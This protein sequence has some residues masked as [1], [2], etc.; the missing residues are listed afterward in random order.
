MGGLDLSKAADQNFAKGSP[1]WGLNYPARLRPTKGRTHT[2]VRV[3]RG[4]AVDGDVGGQYHSG[5]LIYWGDTR[6]AAQGGL[7]MGHTLGAP[8]WGPLE[9]YLGT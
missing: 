7:A 2:R 8:V 9:G 6:E 1:P 5:V 4:E 3:V